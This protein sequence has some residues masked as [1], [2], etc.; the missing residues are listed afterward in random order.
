MADI[1]RIAVL[2]A[3]KSIHTIRWVNALARRGH[4][5]A[6]FSL[7][8]HKAPYSVIDPGV[9]VFYLRRG[10]VAGYWL[11]GPELAGLLKKFKPDVLNAHYATGYGTLARRSG[12]K[13][14]LLSVWG[15]D[16]YEFPSQGSLYRWLVQ[17]NINAAVA[18]ASTSEA[19]ARQVRQITHLDT[20]IYITPFGVDTEKFCAGSDRRDSGEGVTIGFMKALEPIYGAEYLLRAFS[21]LNKR[22]K[23]EGSLPEGGLHLVIYGA[24]SQLKSLRK[25]AKILGIAEQIRFGGSIPHSRVPEAMDGLDIFCAPSICNESFGVVAV[26]AMACGLPVVATDADGFQEVVKDRVTGFIVT[27]RDYVTLSNKLYELAADAELRCRMGEAGRERVRELY[28]WNNCVSA[29][30]HALEQTAA[31]ADKRGGQ[32]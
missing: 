32:P 8:D 11:G 4:T 17:K 9:D 19:M 24:G 1:M 6:L 29:M 10:G 25:L 26:E 12:F 5:V 7:P 14:V 23:R 18:V 2:S 3:A 22:M 31:M 16:V 20:P 27:R 13:P 15:S 28:E 21:L 30:E